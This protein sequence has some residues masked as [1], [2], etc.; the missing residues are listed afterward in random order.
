MNKLY[1]IYEAK[2]HGDQAKEYHRLCD[3]VPNTMTLIRTTDG[4]LFGGWRETPI[5]GGDAYKADPSAFLFS[6]DF[7]STCAQFQNYGMAIADNSSYGPAWSRDL[8][9]YNQCISNSY[10]SFELT[11]TYRFEDA[12]LYSK[13]SLC[14]NGSTQF[15]VRNY[16]VLGPRKP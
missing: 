5:A 16:I 11:H 10:S 15:Q 9:L 1:P 12:G 14:K 13:T 3:G 4:S 2:K 6:V 8:V 7:K